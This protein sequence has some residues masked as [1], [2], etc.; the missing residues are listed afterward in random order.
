MLLPNK[1]R[2]YKPP[3]CTP[4]KFIR[5]LFFCYI[6]WMESLTSKNI[7]MQK[8]FRQKRFLYELGVHAVLKLMSSLHIA[9]QDKMWAEQTMVVF[10]PFYLMF[11]GV[12][13]NHGKMLDSYAIGKICFGSIS[14][15]TKKFLLNTVASNNEPRYIKS[16]LYCL[17]VY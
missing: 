6:F 10:N 12:P 17:F 3:I 11:S 9:I 14:F 16:F 13:W 2:Q 1:F 8:S 4:V 15:W 5:W 7:L